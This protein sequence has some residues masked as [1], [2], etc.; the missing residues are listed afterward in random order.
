MFTIP[1]YF[2]ALAFSACL[3]TSAFAGYHYADLQ[4]KARE[5]GI[6]R[7]AIAAQAAEDADALDRAKKAQKV[8]TKI[9]TRIVHEQAATHTVL[10]Q[11]TTRATAHAIDHAKNPVPATCPASFLDAEQLR[12]LNEA[13]DAGQHRRAAAAPGQP[14]AVLPDHPAAPQQAGQ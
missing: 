2:K 9:E 3:A 12:I 5:V 8:T 11:L 14:D 1:W 13:A 7:A 10:Q 4:A 6:V